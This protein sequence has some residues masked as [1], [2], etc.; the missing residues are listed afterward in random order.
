MKAIVYHGNRDLRLEE[1]PEPEP[2]P[3][4]VKL[5]VDYCGICATDIEEYEYGPK[6]IAHDAPHPLTGR[7]IPLVIGHEL[8][9]TVVATGDGVERFVAGDRVVIYGAVSCGECL[10]CRNDKEILCPSVGFVGFSRDG[11]LAE[12]MTW[13]AS[14]V[15]PVPDGV[16][17][18]QAD[19]TEPTAVAIHAVRR[20]AVGAGQRVAILGT[21]TVRILALQVAKAAGAHAYAVDR[22]QVSLDMA[23]ELG[24]DAAINSDTA[25]APEA[26]KELTGGLGPD[27]VIDAAGGANTTDLAVQLTRCGGKVVIVAIYTSKPAFDFNDIVTREID[28]LG[29]L[30]YT[31]K[32]VREA[33]DLIAEGKVKTMPLASDVIG[34]DQVIDVGY[35]RML[36]PTKDFFRILVDPSR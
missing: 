13:P 23:L 32:E 24:A 10:W 21:G 2:P 27:V 33:V 19:L 31:M 29:S 20:A 5:R 15:I 28:L 1:V 6:F 17:S 8:T 25:D 4:E 34:L 22:R 16:T 7:S 18:Q 3:G 12:Y 9:G 30:G 26:L 35:A 11:G 36:Q 14:R